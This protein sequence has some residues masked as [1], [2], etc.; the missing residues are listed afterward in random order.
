MSIK[1][2]VFDFDGTLVK[3]DTLPFLLSLWRKF[4]YSKQKYYKVYFSLVLLY[5]KYKLGIESKLSREEMKLIAV[6][7]FSNL[8]EGMAEQEIEEYFLRCSE[9]IKDTLNEHVVTEVLSAKTNGYY[10]V[11]LSGTYDYVLNYIGDYLGINTVIGTKINF[12]NGIYDS[13][14]KS[15]IF[16]GIK[17]LEAINKYFN[18]EQ[19]NW[20]ESISFADS[21]SDVHLLRAFGNAV[22]VNPDNKLKEEAEKSNWKIIN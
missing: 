15:E 19:I 16:S 17:K 18:K 3:K 7:K 5:I 1:L 8:F 13:S 22:V 11:L 14:R 2:A 21:Y 20:K 12:N 9:V 10:T 6:D 4:G